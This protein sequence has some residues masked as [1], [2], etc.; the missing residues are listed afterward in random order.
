LAKFFDLQT[1]VDLVE[2]QEV[3]VLEGSVLEAL[4][5]VPSLFTLEELK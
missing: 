1:H 4:S 5:P 2:A 3:L